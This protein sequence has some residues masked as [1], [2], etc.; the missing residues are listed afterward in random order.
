MKTFYISNLEEAVKF[1][2]S[3]GDVVN[4]NA[5]ISHKHNTRTKISLIALG[6]SSVMM[7]NIEL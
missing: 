6:I 2:N 4:Y 3:I 7:N 1:M 5:A